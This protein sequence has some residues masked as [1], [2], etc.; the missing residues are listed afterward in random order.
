MNSL[1][2]II[3]TY[4]SELR[5]YEYVKEMKSWQT[6]TKL[7]RISTIKKIKI[8]QCITRLFKRTIK[9]SSLKKKKRQNF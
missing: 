4:I 7:I 9:I 5:K 8:Y 1:H 2:D 6:Q 3:Y